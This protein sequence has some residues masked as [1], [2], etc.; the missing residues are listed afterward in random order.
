MLDGSFQF[1]LIGSGFSRSEEQYIR[2]QS[3]AHQISPPA[4]ILHYGGGSG[5]LFAEIK[6]AKEA[7]SGVSV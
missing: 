2:E 1:V 7:L 5:L 6:Q 3:I 4:V